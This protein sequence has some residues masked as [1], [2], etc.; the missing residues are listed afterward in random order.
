M[1]AHQLL[2]DLRRRGVVLRADGDLLRFKPRDLPP[3]TI[4]LLREH[5]PVLLRLLQVE[6][7]QPEPTS[8]AC[9]RCGS[10]RFRDVRIHGGQ[11]VRRD[12]GRCGLFWQFVLWY[13]TPSVNYG[14]PPALHHRAA[15]GSRLERAAGEPA[16]LATQ[17]RLA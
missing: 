10:V 15:V 11:S 2:D 6:A 14:R 9:R 16:P 7:S 13:G 12:C 8:P 5:K 3:E 17:S 4:A 1:T